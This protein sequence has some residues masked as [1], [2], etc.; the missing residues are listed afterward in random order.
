MVCLVLFAESDDVIL[1]LVIGY[2]Y[3]LIGQE[4]DSLLLPVGIKHEQPIYFRCLS[5]CSVC[6]TSRLISQVFTLGEI[7]STPRPKVICPPKVLTVINRTHLN[8]W[9]HLPI[10]YKTFIYGYMV[11]RI[12]DNS[13]LE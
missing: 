1:N 2:H 6:Q 8:I 7:N 10:T 3:R 4:Q 9:T 5:P 13:S 11:S 12:Y